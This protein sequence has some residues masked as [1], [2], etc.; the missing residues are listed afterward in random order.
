MFDGKNSITKRNTPLLIPKKVAEKVLN[1]KE[2]GFEIRKYA[3]NHLNDRDGF[4]K[5]MLTEL[6]YRE[7]SFRGAIQKCLKLICT[8]KL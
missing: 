2:F 4:T 7:V 6:I 5:A 1:N 3:Q 8:E